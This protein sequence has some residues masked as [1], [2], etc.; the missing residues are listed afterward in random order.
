M[1]K[2]TAFALVA[3]LTAALSIPA[4][5]ARKFQELGTLD[6]A[7]MT[8]G[9]PDAILCQ[10]QSNAGGAVELYFAQV[11]KFAIARTS[12]VSWDVLTP[13]A[14]A[15]YQDGGLA[16]EYIAEASTGGLLVGTGKKRL[17]LQVSQ[18]SS[19][20]PGISFFKLRPVEK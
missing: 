3:A 10:F 4:S 13:S 6:C 14:S 19:L 11:D 20:E 5:A 8:G 9:A 12:T 2:F 1:R 7:F 16:G 15:K 18:G 17:L